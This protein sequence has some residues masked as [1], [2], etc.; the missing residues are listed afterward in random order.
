MILFNFVQRDGSVIKQP[1][2]IEQSAIAIGISSIIKDKDH[3]F[4]GVLPF[5]FDIDSN[6]NYF[7]AEALLM[8]QY[9]KI[10]LKNIEQDI[11][12]N[13]LHF[14][15]DSNT[16]QDAYYGENFSL[17]F[18]NY[19]KEQNLKTIS[20][21]DVINNKFQ[22]DFFKNKVVF[23]GHKSDIYHDIHLTPLG[24]QLGIVVVNNIFL[25]FL[26]NSFPKNLPL[27]PDI[28]LCFFL[29]YFYLK[30]SSRL[31]KIKN[32]TI[33]SLSLITIWLTDYLLFRQNHEWQGVVPL[34][35]VLLIAFSKEFYFYFSLWQENRQIKNAIIYDASTSLPV[36]S[37]YLMNLRKILSDSEYIKRYYAG[38]LCLTNHSTYKIN[39]K[40]I[41]RVINHKNLSRE[42]ISWDKKSNSFYFL[43]M[44][45]S[46]EKFIRKIEKIQT[47]LETKMQCET[48]AFIIPLS[49][50]K[51]PTIQLILKALTFMQNKE[52]TQK[53]IVVFN[54][55][56]EHKINPD[57]DDKYNAETEEIS[58]AE[59][60][61]RQI[62]KSR[63][64]ISQL[65]EKLDLSHKEIIISQ[66][67]ANVGK[68]A[69]QIVHELKNPLGNLVNMKIWFQQF[70]KPE[71][72]ANQCVEALHGEATRMLDL[73]QRILQFSKPDKEEKQACSI[74][75]LIKE[76][77]EFLEGTINKNHIT[78]KLNLAKNIT[79]ILVNTDQMK[80]VILNL[81]M[82]AIE[83]MESGGEL[84]I[85]TI[86]E[87]N[88]MSIKVTDTGKGIKQEDL[89]KI[90]D[91]FFTTKGDKG[92]GIGLSMCFDIIKKHEGRI[93][94]ESTTSQG[95]TFSVILPI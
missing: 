65:K 21:I 4:R 69:A 91:L 20:F 25:S 64:S 13:S 29:V 73:C 71:D 18:K 9:L 52:S 35:A 8:M 14:K 66:K 56:W 31:S 16:I 41:A 72:P 62:E 23:L 77:L 2:E 59:F 12:K 46:F 50:I 89:D 5:F 63:K 48:H 81:I 51:T 93:L 58:D 57:N 75:H 3:V 83:A 28:L 79:E 53:K 61:T 67:L 37:Y 88:I 70:I 7:C 55:E 42:I 15:S 30:L 39:L 92:T 40:S 19:Y 60:I 87:E 36:V 90:F 34:L 78:L 54:P 95:T 74:N 11:I 80:Q 43:F 1:E 85:E 47:E 33:T 94:V 45:T 68:T 10:P 38:T 82:N 32:I 22:S 76:T 26:N 49:D 84:L 86:V 6:K 27:L 24:S 17:N 44:E